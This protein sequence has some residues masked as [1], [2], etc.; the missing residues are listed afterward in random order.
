MESSIH[1]TVVANTGSWVFLYFF[2]KA[3]FEIPTYIGVIEL[4]NILE[5]TQYA[6]KSNQGK[7]MC[8]AG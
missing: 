8:R 3:I 1:G 7:G 6:G 5:V 4:S 2:I